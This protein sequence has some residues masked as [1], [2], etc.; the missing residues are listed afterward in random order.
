MG[1]H[2]FTWQSEQPQCQLEHS[3]IL[4]NALKL[5]NLWLSFAA[6]V[7]ADVYLSVDSGV[8]LDTKNQWTVAPG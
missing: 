4:C 2:G 5:Y 7:E 6:T 1:I 3:F 8:N